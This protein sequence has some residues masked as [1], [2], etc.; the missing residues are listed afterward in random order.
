MLEARDLSISIHT[1]E[2][3]LQHIYVKLQVRSRM[4][5]ARA[6]RDLAD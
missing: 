1:V 4:E 6:I 5:L 2:A 3:H